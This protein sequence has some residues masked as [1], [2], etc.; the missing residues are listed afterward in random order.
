MPPKQSKHKGSTGR[1]NTGSSHGGAAA[2]GNVNP[3]VV[4]ALPSEETAKPLPTGCELSQGSSVAVGNHESGAHVVSGGNDS[5]TAVVAFCCEKAANQPHTSGEL[6][7]VTSVADGQ[8]YE[9]GASNVSGGNDSHV[10]DVDESWMVMP[11]DSAIPVPTPPSKDVPLILQASKVVDEEKGPNF[12]GNPVVKTEP[13]PFFVDPEFLARIKGIVSSSGILKCLGKPKQL[14]TNQPK[15]ANAGL[16]NRKF[17]LN[18]NVS[19]VLTIFLKWLDISRVDKKNL[20]K[21]EELFPKQLSFDSLLPVQRVIIFIEKDHDPLHTFHND[22]RKIVSSEEPITFKFLYMMLKML[23]VNDRLDALKQLVHRHIRLLSEIEE[24]SNKIRSYDSFLIEILDQINKGHLWKSEGVEADKS[25]V[26]GFV[27]SKEKKTDVSSADLTINKLNRIALEILKSVVSNHAGGE[28]CKSL[29]LL[30]CAIFRRIFAKTS[31]S[32]SVY[33]VFWELLNVCERTGTQEGL[34]MLCFDSIREYDSMKERVLCG[35][36]A[37]PAHLSK[38]RGGT[39]GDLLSCKVLF[40]E[41]MKENRLV[42]DCS[43]T[44]TGKSLNWL[45]A[46]IFHLVVHMRTKSSNDSESAEAS[47]K[48]AKKTVPKPRVSSVF[49]A[50]PSNGSAAYLA[51]VVCEAIEEILR[52]NGIDINIISVDNAIVPRGSTKADTVCV[53]SS[54]SLDFLSVIKKTI[55]ENHPFVVLIDDNPV[56]LTLV[57]RLLMRSSTILKVV[58]C[59][60]SIDPTTIDAALCP[61]IRGIDTTKTLSSISSFGNICYDIPLSIEQLTGIKKLIDEQLLF[62]I[63]NMCYL[64]ILC[65]VL[66][67][68]ST[69]FVFKGKQLIL[70]HEF[71]LRLFPTQVERLVRSIGETDEVFF[72]S[73]LLHFTKLY[74]LLMLKTRFKRDV[75]EEDYKSFLKSGENC[76]VFEVAERFSVILKEYLNKMNVFI[77]REPIPELPSGIIEISNTLKMSKYYQKKVQEITDAGFVLPDRLC[78]PK[79]VVSFHDRGIFKPVL[80]DS[81]G[82]CRLLMFDQ[83]LDPIEIARFLEKAFLRVYGKIKTADEK[84]HEEPEHMQRKNGA[85]FLGAN[86]RRNSKTHNEG[87]TNKP[88]SNGQ[89]DNRRMNDPVSLDKEPEEDTKEKE[90]A[91]PDNE[92]EDTQENEVDKKQTT[93][94]NL[95]MTSSIE[96]QIKEL[97]KAANKVSELLSSAAPVPTN[98]EIKTFVKEL[99]KMKSPISLKLVRLFASGIFIPMSEM[100]FEMIKLAIG[101]LEQGRLIF[102]V[103]EGREAWDMRSQNFQFKHSVFVFFLSEVSSD[104]FLQNCLGRFGRMYQEFPVYVT[105]M[106]ASGRIVDENIVPAPVVKAQGLSP[107]FDGICLDRKLMSRIEQFV[108][109]CFSLSHNCLSFLTDFLAV[110]SHALHDEEF[111]YATHAKSYDEFFRFLCCYL[112]SR[113]CGLEVSGTIDGSLDGFLTDLAVTAKSRRDFVYLATQTTN[114]S[115]VQSFIG[116]L[117]D[118][119]DQSSV[120]IAASLCCAI[121]NRVFP[122]FNNS[123]LV[124]MFFNLKELVKFADLFDAFL[125]NLYFSSFTSING[126]DEVRPMIT[127]LGFLRA[128]MEELSSLIASKVEE[129]KFLKALAEKRRL[130]FLK[131]PEQKSPIECLKQILLSSPQS[132]SEYVRIIQT[133]ANDARECHGFL[134]E[135]NERLKSFGP[136]STML[137]LHNELVKRLPEIDSSDQEYLDRISQLNA[138]DSEMNDKVSTAKQN[139]NNA[140]TPS[141]IVSTSEL[142]K[143][144]NEQAESL[145]TQNNVSRD[146]FSHLLKMNE[147]RRHDML[148]Q[149]EACKYS[150]SKYGQMSEADFLKR[151]LSDVF[152]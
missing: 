69:T 2:S 125:R 93:H 46:S 62:Y 68:S 126:N 50:G 71:L 28:D 101:I 15:S 20:Q 1:K 8:N 140:K 45:I 149:I 47:S 48:G 120:H 67:S 38:L 83:S 81:V 14:T 96:D 94:D 88:T 77:F 31:D 148:G 98:N 79:P 114:D 142:L 54:T 74:M 103:Q 32:P 3:A 109:E 152:D 4:V 122:G 41:F 49:L 36:S 144:L 18:V 102:I 105:C 37:K 151:F 132:I 56:D 75:I 92:Q 72:K 76:D 146:K 145:K 40:K 118:L 121:K 19:E 53:Y 116:R 35:S 80:E 112:S 143:K 130:G 63:D 138:T 43:G 23:D 137:C 60:A 131:A 108:S 113:F 82:G 110:F 124:S 129:G 97:M 44:G 111:K 16:G 30:V 29:F 133:A 58:A 51:K 141:K 150:L 107:N 12:K 42:V 55:D 13:P 100:P 135:L 99:V 17:N 106:T 24:Q 11:N 87:V 52:E 33:E 10:I 26:G 139:V 5:P 89:S 70:V 57:L 39:N 115:V 22:F 104:F 59:G 61:I 7:P 21:F 65:D 73:F 91:S 90:P 9:S 86:S 66:N 85:N 117:S 27:V 34:P 64:A 84:K 123:L 134:L 6:S 147:R 119:L 128:T 136:N 25:S 127:F 78:F 95:D